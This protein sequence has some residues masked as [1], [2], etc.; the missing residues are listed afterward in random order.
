M[1]YKD[2]GNIMGDQTYN[3]LLKAYYMAASEGNIDKGQEIRSELNEYLVSNYGEEYSIENLLADTKTDNSNGT[4]NTV[5]DRQETID[6]LN[7]FI[8]DKTLDGLI[9][10][11]STKEMKQNLENLKEYILLCQETVKYCDDSQ[12]LKEGLDTKI[13]ENAESLNGVVENLIDLSVGEWDVDTVVHYTNDAIQVHYSNCIIYDSLSGKYTEKEL[14]EKVEL[15]ETESAYVGLFTDMYD[16]TNL[17]QNL[18]NEDGSI[19]YDNVKEACSAAISMGDN[20]STIIGYEDY[21]GGNPDAFDGVIQGCIGMAETFDYF[22]RADNETVEGKLNEIRGVTKALDTAYTFISINPIG[23]VLGYPVKGV[24]DVLDTAMEEVIP[25]AVE[26]RVFT[27]LLGAS[28]LDSDADSYVIDVLMQ[29]QD[30]IISVDEAKFLIESH[31]GK[32]TVEVDSEQWDE[33]Q[34]E[35]VYVDP[36]ILDLNGDGTY[37]STLEEGVYFDFEGDGYKEKTAWATEEDG[38]LVGDVNGN[39]IVD[40]GSELFGDQTALSDGMLASSGFEALSELDSDGDSKITDADDL[41]SQLRVWVDENQDGVSQET[42]LHTL[43]EMQIAEISLASRQT[44]RNDGNGNVINYTSSYV[45]KDGKTFGMAE[46]NFD[47]DY[48]DTVQAETVELDA[49][50]INGLPNIT[51]SGEMLDLHQA[52]STDEELK[53]LVQSFIQET[54]GGRRTELLEKIVVKWAGCENID[55]TSRGGNIDAIQLG[56]LEKFYGNEFVGVDGSNPNAPAATILKNMYIDLCEEIKMELLAQTQLKNPVN[57]TLYYKDEE[58]NK[59]IDYSIVENY[60]S[61]QYKKDSEKAVEMMRNYVQY[62]QSSGIS[63]QYFN[64]D[65]L[66]AA[67]AD[68]E[69][70]GLAIQEGILNKFVYGNE[71]DDQ[72]DGTSA[73]EG[74]IGYTGDDVLNG[75]NGDDILDGG[76]GNDTLNGGFGNDVL[77]GGSGDDI[78]DGTYGDDIYV[79][80]KGDG[81]DVISHGLGANNENDV[82]QLEG[83]NREEVVFEVEGNSLVVRILESGESMKISDYFSGGKYR[84]ESIVFADGSS[85]SYKE[86][87]TGILTKE[88]TEGNDSIVVSNQ[89]G[90]VEVYGKEGDDSLGSTGAGSILH[91]GEGKDTLNGSQQADRL[92]GDE[93]NDILN[94]HNGD[95][96]MYGGAGN[97]TLNGGF[98]NDVL[99]GGTGDDMLNGG[100]GNDTYIFGKGY[101]NDVITNSTSSNSDTDTLSIDV[102]A[103]EVIFEKSGSDLLVSILNSDDTL[104][105]DNW[106]S[107]DKNKIENISTGDGYTLSYSQVDLLIQ[108]MSSFE[109]A[110][111]MSW[112][113]AVQNNNDSVDS[114]VSQMWIKQENV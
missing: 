97:D 28:L 84:V 26:Q 98:G 10:K 71:G 34:R 67:F 22:S 92:Y 72:V 76:A 106:Y 107:S 4:E 38:L 114:L 3:E 15:L 31:L 54:Y 14:E 78:L 25:K 9:D 29:C 73:S 79:Y 89:N 51:A 41:Y 48:M 6:K 109:N 40:N 24:V 32:G 108:A 7:S 93:G 57:L 69:V 70:F 17:I 30:G 104:T 16:Y 100:A 61:Y 88:G 85:I 55:P 12:G 86:L 47:I 62:L 58:G 105:I 66:Q 52:M 56:V 80:G 75:H 83:L 65:D 45:T 77:R 87:I 36:V 44:S 13:L 19:N 63:S 82:L 90:T 81:N 8:E 99:N 111:G 95:D 20:I 110:S 91:G 64:T 113:E 27:D 46:L 103:K 50:A 33:A 43:G 101:G 35:R 5:P 37:A 74:V 23:A 60:F 53:S 96:V 42:E 59:K 112:S 49:E 1:A 94:G 2:F 11:A 39:G 102:D 68:K 21:F 18:H